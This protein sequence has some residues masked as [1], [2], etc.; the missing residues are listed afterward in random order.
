[1][2][3]IEVI[4]LIATVIGGAYILFDAIFDRTDSK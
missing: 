2:E 4:F 1:M 3:T